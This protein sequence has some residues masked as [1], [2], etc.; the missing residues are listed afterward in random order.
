M[1]AVGTF[2]VMVLLLLAPYLLFAAI[3]RVLP[4]RDQP[5]RLFP[6]PAE[7]PWPRGVQEEDMPRWAFDIDQAPPIN[8]PTVPD[9]RSRVPAVG[10]RGPKEVGVASLKV[11]IPMPAG[12]ACDTRRTAG[13]RT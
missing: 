9:E 10:T 11:S 6:P 12:T 2:L 5:L 4:G 13:S 7:L 8:G 1:E 3:D